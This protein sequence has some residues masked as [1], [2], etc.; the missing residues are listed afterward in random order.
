MEMHSEIVSEFGGPRSSK[1]GRETF[2]KQIGGENSDGK[3]TAV[4]LPLISFQRKGLAPETRD[5]TSRQTLHKKFTAS[6]FNEAW[7]LPVI[8]FGGSGIS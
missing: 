1:T 4:K 3:I 7:I 6:H 2:L 5:K 8:L